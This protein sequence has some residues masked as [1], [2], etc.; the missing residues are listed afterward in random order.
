MTIRLIH[1]PAADNS[2]CVATP[3]RSNGWPAVVTARQVLLR[4]AFFTCMMFLLSPDAIAQ[5]FVPGYVLLNNGDT[6]QGLIGEENWVKAP[7]KVLFKKSAAE[8]VHAYS[9][10][11]IHSFRIKD[12]DWYFS[13]VGDIDPSSLL[14]DQLDYNPFPDT[15]RVYMFIRSI[16]MGKISL[17]YARDMNDRLHLFIQKDGGVIAELKYKK[18]YLDERVV[19][20]YRNEITRRA[21]MA[22][23]IYKEQLTNLMADCPAVA[24]GIVSRPLSYSKNDIMKLV[25]EYNHC[26]G[27]RKG[28]TEE[29]EPWKLEVRAHLG[30]NYS[31]LKFKSSGNTYVGNSQ[32]DNSLGYASGLS[33]NA[34]LPRTDNSWGIYNE[35]LIRNFN[36]TGVSGTTPFKEQRPVQMDLIYVKLGTMARYRFTRS[37]VQPFLAAGITNSI[38]IKSENLE[39]DTAGITSNFLQYFRNYEQGLLFG[40]GLQWKAI[41]GEVQLEF[42]NGMSGYSDVKSAFSTLY[43]LVGYKF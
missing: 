2:V 20:D 41:S 36:S 34:V 25:I 3:S 33:F 28:Y 42:S 27:S 32:F 35:V 11:L 6:L 23:Q 8:R 18:Y 4:I 1:Y 16:V 13:F 10:L 43:L 19:A 7:V 12:G 22:N 17:Y 5:K 31:G 15:M 37:V 21:I 24:T 38:A 40:A 26:K 39:T 29:K 9:P 14:D 30:I